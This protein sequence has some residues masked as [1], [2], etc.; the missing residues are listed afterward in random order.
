MN[1]IYNCKS[2]KF[3]KTCKI[4]KKR[5]VVWNLDNTIFSIFYFFLTC[6]VMSRESLVIAI[7]ER[8]VPLIKM[9]LRN[10]PA[11]NVIKH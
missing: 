3:I 6:I 11:A 5:T 1:D 10:K 7:G 4:S 9:A 8:A 2:L